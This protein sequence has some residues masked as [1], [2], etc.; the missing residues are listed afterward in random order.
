[1]DATNREVFKAVFNEQFAANIE[2]VSVQKLPH[3]R[4]DSGCNV[5]FVPCIVSRL[6]SAEWMCCG[7]C[8]VLGV[9]LGVM[10]CCA[11]L[12]SQGLNK[13]QAAAEALASAQ[14]MLAAATTT[15]AASPSPQPLPSPSSSLPLPPSAS[16]SEPAVVTAAPPPVPQP[17]PPP[18]PREPEPVRVSAALLRGLV[19]Q[20]RR[21]SSFT[22]VINQSIDQS[23]N[24]LN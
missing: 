20:C 5:S 12:S 21:D 19:E 6:V 10:L 16:K 9:V 2:K 1:M 23:I 8:V 4:D 22:P 18:V 15:T 7:C 3:R 17:V 11:V 24:K 13:S 14:Q